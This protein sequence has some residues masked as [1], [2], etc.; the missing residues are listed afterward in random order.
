MCAIVCR[1]I[2]KGSSPTAGIVGSGDTVQPGGTLKKIELRQLWRI[3][4]TVNWSAE[5]SVLRT[6]I[7][8]HWVYHEQILV[9]IHVWTYGSKLIFILSSYFLYF[10]LPFFDLWKR[11]KSLRKF[12]ICGTRVASMVF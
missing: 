3:T 11:L 1:D 12:G 9:L 8:D 6:V 5:D 4:N 2:E 7:K 10:L